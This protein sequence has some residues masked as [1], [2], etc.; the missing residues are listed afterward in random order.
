MERRQS[1]EKDSALTVKAACRDADPCAWRGDDLFLAIRLVNTRADPVAIPLAYLK[2]TG[3]SIRLVDARSGADTQLRTNL[4]D[5][6]LRRSLTV[7]PS[8]EAVV[9]DW[10]VHESELLQFGAEVDLTA[11]I[12]V[13]GELAVNGVKERFEAR[14]ALRITGRSPP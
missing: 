10:V 9:F 13:F 14:D 7:V 12:T 6:D 1:T 4:A 8:G 11:E 2:K 5:P 3:P